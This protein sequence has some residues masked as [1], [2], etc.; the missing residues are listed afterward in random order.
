MLATPE[1]IRAAAQAGRLVELFPQWRKI[2]LYRESLARHSSGLAGLPV[3]TKR[4]MRAGFPHN[5]LSN[6][7]ALDDLLAKELVE[8]EHTSGTSE[9]RLP[10]IMP[11]GWWNEQEERALRLNQFVARVLDEA[12]NAR[13][14][15]LTAPACNGLTCPTVWMSQAQRTIGNTLYVNLARIP[16]V[17][18]DAELQRMADEIAAWSPQFLDLDPV[19]GVWFALFCERRGIR[20]PSVRFVICS[21]E[22]VSVVHRRILQRVF[23][24]PVFNLYGSTETG[25]LLMEN[26]A[27]EMK[28]SYETAV[29]EVVEE[30]ELLAASERQI[31]SLE[32]EHLLSPSLSSILNGGEGGR[33]PGE[34]GLCGFGVQSRNL[35]S[36]RGVAATSDAV[37][38]LLVTTLSNDYMPLLRYRIGDLVQRHERAYGTDY[39]IHG[40]MR[41]A[42]TAIDGRRV[43]TWQVDQCFA[44]VAGIAHYQ[45]RQTSRAGFHLRYIPDRAGMDS[46]S[47]KELAARLTTLLGAP[48]QVESVPTLLP[49]ASGKFRLTCRTDPTT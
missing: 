1:W 26:E 22:F 4:D 11:R 23:G 48:V 46:N 37:G 27:G 2:P 32:P 29:L 28:P 44:G 43:T 45:L 38:T 10:V 18:S 19:H 36:G 9:D 33:R 40:R 12:P 42:L 30:D 34:E 3:I 6:T 25:H 14:A 35:A 49:E 16:F 17:L 47:L 5:F 7:D 20:F 21:Y 13:R 24:G 31:S 41:D 15:T 8:I 39:T